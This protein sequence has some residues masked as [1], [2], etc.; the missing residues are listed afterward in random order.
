LDRC[1]TAIQSVHS[2]IESP[3]S[4]TSNY[5]LKSF[6][7]WAIHESEILF[8]KNNLKDISNSEQIDSNIS[9]ESKF[10]K[11][12]VSEKEP[13]WLVIGIP[14]VARVHSED[15]LLKSLLMIANQLPSDP[16]DLFYGKVLVN[17]VNV[18]VFLFIYD[19]IIG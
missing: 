13:I 4:N 5:G 3:T 14:T 19:F 12:E 6:G 8:G 7:N 16:S 2:S 9:P 18:Q 15:Y 17:V 1:H 10:N 11:N